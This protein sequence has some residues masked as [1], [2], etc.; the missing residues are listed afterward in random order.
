M[1][2]LSQSSTC[3][4]C[5]FDVGNWT[6][7]DQVR[8]VG[9]VA[10]YLT[11]YAVEGCPGELL[12]EPSRDG[13][14]IVEHLENLTNAFRMHRLALLHARQK[15]DDG[16]PTPESTIEAEAAALFD[17]YRA[18]HDDQWHDQVDVDGHLATI[19]SWL[20]SLTHQLSHTV[21]EIALMRHDLGDIV[22]EMSGTVQQISVSNGG[23]PKTAIDNATVAAAGLASD[24]QSARQ[25]H[26]RPWQALCL[27]S[28]EVIEALQAE[29]HPIGFGSAGE[30]VTLRGIDWSK[31][32]SGLEVEIGEVRARLT[33]PATPCSKN[34]QWFSHEDSNRINHDLHPGWS[35]WYALVVDGGDIAEGDKVA[36][37]SSGA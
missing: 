29:G 15:V 8:T 26:G 24:T 37:R 36:A 20:A 6:R 21:H 27:Y 22:A 12:N 14:S 35:R 1:L 4:R 17:L 13:R 28:A 9:L 34:H 18:L 5:A 25:H 2:N 16:E 32:R 19:E 31:M 3:P 33:A 23:V 10:P 11:S 7:Q 30:N